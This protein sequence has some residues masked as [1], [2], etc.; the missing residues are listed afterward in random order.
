MAPWELD[1]DLWV[2]RAVYYYETA[3][4]AVKGPRDRLPRNTFVELYNASTKEWLAEYE[5][6]PCIMFPLDKGWEAQ[7]IFYKSINEV[8]DTLSQVEEDDWRS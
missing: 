4:R 1:E 7:E 6:N 5:T 2:K 3:E 8:C